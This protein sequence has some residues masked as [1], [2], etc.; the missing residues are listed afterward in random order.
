MTSNIVSF[1]DKFSG[2]E[3]QDILWD[4]MLEEL[5][6]YGLGEILYTFS[7]FP[8]H[9][10]IHDFARGA[11]LK[12]N[13]PEEYQEAKNNFIDDPFW[14]I[15]VFENQT[16]LWSNTSLVEDLPPEQKAS[17]DIDWDFNIMTGVALSS[18]F[19]NGHGGVAIGLHAPN[20][21]WVEFDKIWA[22][23]EVAITDLAAAFDI[24][25]RE[26]H[27][28]GIYPLSAREKEC[29]LW[30]SS[31]LRPQQIAYRLD[32]SPKTVEKH[33]ASARSKLGADTVAQAVAKSLIFGLINP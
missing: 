21:S 33:I 23:H 27:I 5:K 26:D 32:I 31:G 24:C 3:G 11:Y 2:V 20:M 15:C 19:N 7:T 30:L 10:S 28:D 14:D 22:E 25:M 18:R 4:R 17:V 16:V 8:N 29:L 9:G 1:C 6:P 12:T 13:Y